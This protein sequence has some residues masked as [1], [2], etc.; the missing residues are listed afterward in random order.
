MIVL[1]NKE[2]L[3]DKLAVILN[4]SQ[5][6][7]PCGN[8]FWIKNTGLALKELVNSGQVIISSLGLL[9]WEL[10]V[11][12]V[13]DANGRQ[14]IISPIFDNADGA[15]I[16]Q[17]TIDDFELEPSKVAMVF[18][19]PDSKSRSPK[20]NWLKRDEA[21][22]NSA[23]RIIPISIRQ[24]GRLHKLLANTADIKK[25]DNKFRIEYQKSI[26]KPPQYDIAQA[27][28][29]FP[30]W[31]FITHWTRTHHGPWP[32]EK[33]AAF[34]H[35][36][37]NSGE[38]YPNNAFNT[39]LNMA[40]EK[41]IRA[42]SNK[43]RDARPVIGFSEASPLTILKLLRWCPRQVNWNFE[44]YGI[45]ITRQAAKTLGIRPAIYGNDE[46]Y[47][48]LSEFDK[49]YF[50]NHGGVEVD[51]RLEK[52]WRHAGDLKLENLTENDIAY[53]VWKQDEATQLKSATQA[54]V[55]S[56]NDC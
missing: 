17:R 31:D 28:N 12:L 33:S 2:L 42:S 5:S 43:I 36:L 24:N 44:P 53:I 26:V 21:A 34:Y 37:I 16:F 32:D 41:K 46:T 9:T 11:H 49:P 20:D 50:Q 27:R 15:N 29:E 3:N 48:H 47:R 54:R 40:N 56:F 39:L 4:S 51:W 1:G 6:K 14:V 35:R 38:K 45:A 19:K 22:L 18:V 8:D 7:T 10:I 13:Q 30:D 52:E 25:I 23:Q 55:F